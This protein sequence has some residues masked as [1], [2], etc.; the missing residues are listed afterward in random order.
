[1][2]SLSSIATADRG[3]LSQALD[4][5]NQHASQT[6][7][8]TTFNEYTS[9]P[10]SSSGGEGKG[11]ASELQGG[12]SGL[13]NKFRAS[14][15]NVRDRVTLAGDSGGGDEASAKIPNL[16]PSS[17]TSVAWSKGH[18]IKS[19]TS[20]VNPG[21][22]ETVDTSGQ[23]S[24]FVREDEQTQTSNPSQAARPPRLPLGS[25]SN[26]SFKGS[27]TPNGPFQSH[28]P[29]VAMATTLVS[30][31]TA[32]VNVRAGTEVKS[33]SS[34][35]SQGVVYSHSVSQ[36]EEHLSGT[37]KKQKIAGLTPELPLSPVLVRDSPEPS[38]IHSSFS[39]SDH[40]SEKLPLSAGRTPLR[41][42]KAARTSTEEAGG[43]ALP[44]SGTGPEIDYFTPPKNVLEVP[45]IITHPGSPQ[46]GAADESNGA[47]RKI[48]NSKYENA[49]SFQHL[50]L[51]A[52][53]SQKTSQ[54][55]SHTK[56]GITTPQPGSTAFSA[57]SSMG[58]P[59]QRSSSSDES[60]Y[61]ANQRGG[62][63]TSHAR[64]PIKPLPNNM[65]SRQE[66]NQTKG[67]VLNKEYWMKDENARDCFYCGDSFS[68]FRRKHHCSKF[69]QVHVFLELKNDRS[70]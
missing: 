16:I 31:A 54:Y 40:K 12:L 60:E 29:P 59:T 44:G 15:G 41:D 46:L 33:S 2:T 53:I 55:Y 68:T 58:S 35:V 14:V 20:S 6:D 3:T 64:I 19:S 51:P 30:P 37:A 69:I 24:S 10:L 70:L 50:E 66:F 7:S 23:Q 49:E 39:K 17:S 38:P 57:V 48:R 4:Q 67:K 65:V 63:Q 9:P 11:I 8:L 42:E 25:A 13:Y 22:L 1:M 52:H 27:L 34:S 43:T 61:P 32:E 21:S 45:K 28:L 36:A 5:I 56:S 62:S 26:K 47:S 18:G